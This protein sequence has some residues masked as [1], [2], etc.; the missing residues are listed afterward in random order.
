M[1]RGQLQISFA[2]LFA[3]IVG[4]FILFLAIFAT[5]KIINTE[6]TAVDAQTAKEIGVLLNPL[7][8][9]FETGKK[10]TLILPS[11][12][13]IYNRCDNEGVFGGQTIRISQKSFNKWTDTDVN[14]RLENKNIF[15][16][17]YS[18]GKKF[19]LFSKPFE[20]PFKV[21]D[22][23]YLISSND[24]YCFADAPDRVK[25]E[26]SNLNLENIFFTNCPAD[27]IEVCFN[28]GNCDVNV[29]EN[30]YIVE[31]DENLTKYYGDSLMYATIFS[32]KETYECQL[33]RLMQRGKELALIYE[34]KAQIVSQAGCSSNLIPELSS[35]TSS[36]E[37]FE[38]SASLNQMINNLENLK[39]KN[40]FAECKLW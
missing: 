10:T 30:N 16:G 13:R 29:D 14:I 38:N 18:E 20:F 2:W 36:E 31:K 15:S 1:K 35:L 8:T 40:G 26:I 9:G 6:Q 7:E 3:I 17:N 34:D 39:E 21:A 25:E 19:F 32:D 24:N 27:S 23:I 37:S 22:V 12:T 33:K 5:T 4:A 11:E 28:G